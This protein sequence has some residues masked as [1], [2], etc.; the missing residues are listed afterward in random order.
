MSGKLQF[1]YGFIP[2]LRREINKVN[3]IAHDH[4]SFEIWRKL[5]GQIEFGNR[6]NDSFFLGGIFVFHRETV[7]IHAKR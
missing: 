4:D 1:I 7:I 6:N 2:I 3:K 5:E